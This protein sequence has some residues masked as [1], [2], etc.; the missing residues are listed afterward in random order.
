VKK[1]IDYILDPKPSGYRAIHLDAIYED[2]YSD[3]APRRVELQLRTDRQHAWADHVE[4]VGRRMNIALKQG[5]GPQA[6]LDNFR[7]L[8][9]VYAEADVGHL[10]SRRETA[11]EASAKAIKARIQD[12]VAEGRS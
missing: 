4:E 9:D 12:L 11:L 3:N 10:S 7:D 5:R 1:T 8:A 2:R 6:L